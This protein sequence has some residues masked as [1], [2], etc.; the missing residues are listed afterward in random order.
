MTTLIT[1]SYADY[2]LCAFID[3]LVC[4]ILKKKLELLCQLPRAQSDTCLFGPTNSTNLKMIKI[5]IFNSLLVFSYL[6]TLKHLL[7]KTV[8]AKVFTKQRLN[9]VSHIASRGLSGNILIVPARRALLLC[10][11]AQY[12]DLKGVASFQQFFALFHQRTLPK[13]AT[14]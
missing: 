11:A 4:K 8:D 1:D 13:R 2:F 9:N 10:G 7:F 3:C 6:S 12:V 5:I 14:L